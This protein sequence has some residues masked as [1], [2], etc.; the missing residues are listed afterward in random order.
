MPG[1]RNTYT[2]DM[3]TLLALLAA[4]SEFFLSRLQNLTNLTSHTRF[5]PTL[6]H[7][8]AVA[9]WR[10]SCRSFLVLVLAVIVVVVAGRAMVV[11]RLMKWVVQPC[12]VRQAHLSGS[13]GRGPWR[14]V[15]W[16]RECLTL[17]TLA[18]THVGT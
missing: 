14:R 18:A 11:S 4:H 10:R 5:N 8:T 13:G 1:Q 16:I 6:T 7:L 12:L 2:M 9:A 15:R 17:R 3:E